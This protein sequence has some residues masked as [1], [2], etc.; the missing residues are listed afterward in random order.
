MTTSVYKQLELQEE[1]QLGELAEH[2]RSLAHSKHEC[3]LN[4]VT[5]Q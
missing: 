1:S 4:P 2:L 3:G 5:L